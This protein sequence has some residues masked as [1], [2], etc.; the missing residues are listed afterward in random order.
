MRPAPFLWLCYFPSMESV[1]VLMP[2]LRF[3]CPRL[4]IS[5]FVI[6]V[7]LSAHL[8]GAE[9][10]VTVSESD[11]T[12]T[13]DNGTV[14]ARVSKR[15]G[16][17]ISLKY[18]ELEMLDNVAQRQPG[19]WS[20]N[21]ARGERA[22]RVSID[23]KTNGGARGEVSIKGTA[24]GNQ[25]GSGPGG[26]VVADIE[27]RYTLGRDDSGV[28]TYSI[29]SHPTNYPGTSLGE[30]RFCLKLNDDVFDWMTVD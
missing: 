29:L 25:M 1:C 4:K 3:A 28:Y 6:G 19:Y 9:R 26:S 2:I 22:T 10:M 27:I 12:F 13:L 17:L 8:A 24:N 18:R 5:L 21:V 7:F 20:H 30:A 14:A 11:S 15:S 23:P 16:D